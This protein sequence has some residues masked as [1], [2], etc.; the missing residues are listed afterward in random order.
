MTIEEVH[1]CRGAS[2]GRF[3]AVMRQ[4]ACA[5]KVAAVLWIMAFALPGCALDG[6]ANQV[7]AAA[8]STDKIDEMNRR[9]ARLPR[10]EQVAAEY[11]A[12]AWRIAAAVEKVAPEMMWEEG[13]SVGKMACSGDLAE[14]DGFVISTTM[15]V[16]SVP[17]PADKWSPAS[18]AVQSVAAEFGLTTLTTRQDRPGSHDVMLSG[19][20]GASVTFG[21][22]KAA[23]IA[24][25]T[26]C[27]LE[28]R[29]ST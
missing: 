6:V 10:L 29:R 15:L 16:S 18:A 26:P 22:R 21:S 2:L 1:G 12:F 11:E 17:I 7:D 27:R 14:S 28:D 3:G 5:A 25:T 24:T 13:Q 23:L 8:D 19:H 20:D 9:L 4:R